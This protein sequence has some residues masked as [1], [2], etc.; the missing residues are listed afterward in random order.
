MRGETARRSPEPRRPAER[1]ARRR[2]HVVRTPAVD[3]AQPVDFEEGDAGAVGL[4]LGAQARKAVED[5]VP[6]RAHPVRVG[7]HEPELGTARE[8]LPHAHAG[9]HAEGLGGRR[10]LPDRLPPT[11]LGRE[12]DGAPDEVGGVPDRGEEREPGIQG[13]GDHT[14]T[15]S[16]IPATAWVHPVNGP[17]S[18]RRAL[19]RENQ[20]VDRT[21][22]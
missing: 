18:A 1:T 16:H 10:H 8:R 2:Q 17:I 14:N 11:G 13:A 12:G 9:D 7:R 20:S 21:T 22:S 15:C 19:K 5:P 4:A 6:R 3:P